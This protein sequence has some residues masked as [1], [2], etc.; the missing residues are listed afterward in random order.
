[1]P[2]ARTRSR[3]GSDLIAEVD[4]VIDGAV[5]VRQAHDIGEALQINLESYGFIERV[6][7]APR[8]R[9]VALCGTSRAHAPRTQ[10]FIHIDYETSRYAEHNVRE[11]PN[12]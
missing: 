3:S 5:P 10:A 8:R 1:L 6:R 12:Q 11:E 4:I 2:R 9:R 7:A